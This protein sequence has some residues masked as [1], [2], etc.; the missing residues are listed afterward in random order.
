[1]VYLAVN[2]TWR[3]RREYGETYYRKF[4][5]Q[6]IH[7]LGLSH[8]LGNQKRFVVRTDRRQYQSGDRAVASVEAYDHNYE[9]LTADKLP[10][11]QLTGELIAP[12]G[13][14]AAK[15]PKKIRLSQF[16][17]GVFQTE[18]DVEEPGEYV[19]RVADPLSGEQVDAG[20]RVANLSAERRSA[21]RNV[22]LE[23]ELAALKSER[24]GVTGERFDETEASRLPERIFVPE[25]AESSIE[26]LPLWNTWPAFLVIV[27]LMLVEWFVRKWVH[28]P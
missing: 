12:S 10:Q 5:G 23:T 20:F 11:P 25:E 17:D 6:M 1:V 18:F 9:P 27:V 22:A 15:P 24:F 21:V 14:G 8:A 13:T 26:R 4:W 7:R 19:V 3:L 28:L 2:E 16:R